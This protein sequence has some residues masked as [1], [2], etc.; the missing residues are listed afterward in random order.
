MAHAFRG[1]WLLWLAMGLVLGLLIGGWWPSTSL[2]AVATD[3]YDTFAIA[4]GPVDEKVEA[5]FFLD[6]LT[7]DLRAAVLNQ[8]GKFTAFYQYNIQQ[9]LGIEKGKNPRYLLVTGVND[10]RRGA[11]RLRPS[12]SIVYVAEIN[13]G[14]VAA[15]AI[16]WAPDSWSTAQV[17]KAQMV[18]LDAT[19][20]R[21]AAVRPQE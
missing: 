9:D 18:P 5:I 20:F 14:A 6:F 12:R 3:R 21:T 4:T 17:I 2:H 13:S 1:N 11:A 16:P 10:I 8:F 7:G 19:K 15:Y